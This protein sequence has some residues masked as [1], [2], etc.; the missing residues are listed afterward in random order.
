VL[1]ADGDHFAGHV[2]GVV[3][4]QEDDDVGDLAWFGGA[5]EG[6][7]AG[8]VGEQVLAGDLGQVRVQ[9]QAGGDGVDADAVRGDVQRV[10]AITPA[11]AA[12]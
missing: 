9:G 2:A 1:G 8:Q 5:A 7:A 12:A 11:L 6:L 10:K 3:A 4:G